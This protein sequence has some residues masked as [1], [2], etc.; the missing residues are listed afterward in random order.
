MSFRERWRIAGTIA[1]EIRFHGMLEAN[2]SNLSRIKEKPE[3]IVKQIKRSASLNAIMT[4]FVIIMIGFL[5]V[6]SI[7]ILGDP[8]QRVLNFTISFGVFLGLGFVIIF[9]VN[10]TSA[11]GFFNA[12]AM[13]LPSTLPLSRSDLENL[14]ILV[15]VRIFIAPFILLLIVFPLMVSLAFGILTGLFVLGALTITLVLALSALIKAAGWFHQKSQSG[16]ESV[17]SVIIRVGAGIGMT[18]G[19][20][21]AY[22]AINFIPP[23]IDFMLFLSTA[24]SPEVLSLFALI[25]PFSF[26]FVAALI[27]YGMV[28]SLPTSII[29]IVA[30]FLYLLLSVR[31]YRSSGRI[32]HTLALGGVPMAAATTTHPIDLRI[33]SSI[34]ALIKKDLRVATRSL[35]SIMLLV[36]PFLMI[37]VIIP[38]LFIGYTESTVIRSFSVL[39]VVGYATMF[40]GLSMMGLL[41]LDT[42]GASVYEGLPLRT[43]Q[44]LN[45]KIAVFGT[46]YAL[47]LVIVFILLLTSRIISPFLLFVPL[48]QIPCAYS[49]GAAVGG[50][51]YRTRGGGRVTSVNLVGDQAT[52]F[53]SLIVSV[54]VGVVPLLGYSII[55]LQTGNHLFSIITQLLVSLFEMIL[56]MIVLPRILKD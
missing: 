9:F 20:V 41:G 11:T 40:A 33:S 1:Q 27:T 55:L 2:P 37:F 52:S 12:G 53:I 19:I 14:M 17:F 15:F 7:L 36:F 4:G 8:N 22:S 54:A 10:L 13:L 5:L 50:V 28:F 3:R 32:L 47:T 16:D 42:Q 30:S 24:I 35:G 45:S 29:A 26:G 25:F 56:L 6:V 21:M 34:P 18:V 31:S 48:F 44:V 23:I 43:S 39:L 49:I 51:I 46:S 38:P